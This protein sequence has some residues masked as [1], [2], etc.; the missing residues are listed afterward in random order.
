[1]KLGRQRGV[2]DHTILQPLFHELLLEDNQAQRSVGIRS[3]LF[4]RLFSSWHLTQRFFAQWRQKWVAE[5]EQW[6]E[7]IPE[8]RA[9]LQKSESQEPI[10]I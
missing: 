6:Q 10:H 4:I 5:A 7:R 3:S 1:L 2:L 8:A 9:F